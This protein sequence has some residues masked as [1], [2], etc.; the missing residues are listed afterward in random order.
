MTDDQTTARAEVFRWPHL[1]S[2]AHMYADPDAH[3]APWVAYCYGC[4]DPHV[5]RSPT[6][7]EAIAAL[8][9]HIRVEHGVKP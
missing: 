8:T 1:P 5:M 7:A 2:S 4:L 3:W 9:K 6:H